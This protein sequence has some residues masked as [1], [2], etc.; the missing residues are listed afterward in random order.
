MLRNLNIE[1]CDKKLVVPA[2]TKV[3]EL[4]DELNIPLEKID[5][6]VAAKV[7]NKV[8]SLNYKL[9]ADSIVKLITPKDEFGFRIYVNSLTFLLFHSFYHFYP[10]KRLVISHSLSDGLYFYLYN[11][12][13]VTEEMVNQIESFMKKVVDIHLP[14]DIEFWE[15]DEALNNFIKY[16]DKY[17]FLKYSSLN[18][19]LVSHIKDFYDISLTPLV[20]NT[21]VL[22]YFKLSLYK[23]GILLRYPKRNEF[24]EFSEFVDQK[25]LFYVYKEQEDWGK[26]LGF[27]NLG[28]LNKLIVNKKALEVILI[29][30]ALQNKKIVKIV[31]D[32][33]KK[34][35]ARIVLIAGPSSSGKTTF[36]K[37]LMVYLRSES[38]SSYAISLDNY[39]LNRE[40]T[41]KDENGDYDFEALEALDIEL[42]NKNLN[43]ILNG[44]KT[45]LPIF[46]FKIGRRSNEYIEY[47]PKG[48]EII[49]IEGIHG[50][51]PRLTYDVDN[52]FKFK[53]YISPL[54]QVNI[55]DSVRI[56]TT[57]AR[58]FRRLVRDYRYRGIS[59]DETLSRW[60][61]V[62][63]G[64]ERNIFP[65]Q[66][67][68]DQ[69]FNSA[70]PYELSVLRPFAEPLLKS[71]KKDSPNYP[72]ANFLSEF[73]LHFL[74]IPADFVPTTS[75]LREFI[76]SALYLRAK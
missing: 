35:N 15:K 10:E 59:A 56:P 69:Y 42:F 65:F 72:M 8:V 73:I 29:S 7:N 27:E 66:N 32:I 11:D 74:P 33:K 54:T 47:T 6:Y 26:I 46:D 20:V 61:S 58:L 3:I 40:Q 38:I 48:D 12:E 52:K 19:V 70:L 68:A 64:E 36:S 63:R 4:T 71:I 37:K 17:N 51:N 75:I 13:K 39:F 25:K 62:R 34:E 55:T 41:P 31:D 2:N 43:S 14:I 28:K 76:G 16:R 53:I 24:P 30:E 57:I 44:E 22:K 23:D 50:L 9:K 21:G 60:P 49:I 45:K 67:E 1:I 5:N 18:A